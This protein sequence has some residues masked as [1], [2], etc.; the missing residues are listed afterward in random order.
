MKAMVSGFTIFFPTNEASFDQVL[1]FCFFQ[2]FAVSAGTLENL[3]PGQI[4]P[5]RMFHW[6]LAGWAWNGCYRF[7]SHDL[8]LLLIKWGGWLILWMGKTVILMGWVN[9]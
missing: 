4:G 5:L 6:A 2:D 9:A 3:I 8:V 1:I 7:L